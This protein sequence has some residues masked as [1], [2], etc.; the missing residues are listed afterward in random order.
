M[1]AGTRGDALTR[2]L[3]P[4]EFARCSPCCWPMPSTVLDDGQVG[5]DASG[6]YSG[7][8]PRGQASGEEFIHRWKKVSRGRRCR[9]TRTDILRRVQQGR[10]HD[11]GKKSLALF[12]PALALIRADMRV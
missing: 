8:Q 4:S 3:V 7:E 11:F 5:A 1:H 2:V 10:E 6:E 12:R 9:R